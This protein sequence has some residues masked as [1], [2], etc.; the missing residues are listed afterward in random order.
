M[1][2]GIGSGDWQSWLLVTGLLIS[3]EVGFP[4]PVVY[5]SILLYS[6][7]K[8][9]Q[10]QFGYLAVAAFGSVGSALGA[11][12][13]F[14]VFFFLGPPILKFKFF[15][16]HAGRIEALKR[17][18]VK[19]EILTVAVGRLTPGLLNLTSLTA[20]VLRLNYLKFILGVLFSNLV[21]ASLLISSGYVLGRVY[22]AGSGLE[23]VTRKISLVLGLSALVIFLFIFKRIMS[24]VKNASGLEEE[25]R[26]ISG[27]K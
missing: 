19:D 13:L 18:L 5:E 11:S 24:R 27:K 10:N 14:L 4:L 15:R 1:L 7:Y 21:W 25:A 23:G 22:P 8:L 20:G 17:E 2:A 3:N 9:A 26:E 16:K 12:L 6:G